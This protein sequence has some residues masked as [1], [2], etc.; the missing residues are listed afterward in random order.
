MKNLFEQRRRQFQQELIK[1]LPY[2]FN[3]HFVLVLLVGLGVVLYQ[4]RQLLQ[5]FPQQTGLI[6]LVLTLLFAGFISLGRVATA[7]KPADKHFLLPKEAQLIALIK[8]ALRRAWIS[9][10]LGLGLGLLALYPLLFRLSWSW[11]H[12]VLALAC[13]SGLQLFILAQQVKQI[14]PQGQVDWDRLIATEKQRQQTILGFFALFT[15]VKGLTTAVK[16]RPYLNKLL[17]LVPKGQGKLYH[18]LYWRAFLR[19]GDYLGLFIRLTV[20]S[21]MSLFGVNLPF[22]GVF[23]ALVFNFLLI[24]QLLGLYRHYDYQ[25]LLGLTPMAGANQAAALLSLI[26]SLAG[27]MVV[28]ELPFTKSWSAALLLTLI[29]IIILYVYLPAKVKRAQLTANKKTGKIGL[30]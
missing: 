23:L 20:L 18:H 21:V 10:S 7:V 24:F 6:Y 12:L 17:F 26:R 2:V 1:Y 13:L 27:L 29:T 28:L 5:D 25:Y 9:K 14:L 3:D 15:R 22:L 8:E 11:W 30:F 19:S 4:Y 16:K